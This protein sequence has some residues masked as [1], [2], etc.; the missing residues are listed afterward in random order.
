MVKRVNRF[1]VSARR[2]STYVRNA[3]NSDSKSEHWPSVAVGQQWEV[4]SP[5]KVNDVLWLLTWSFPDD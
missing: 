2:Q 4:T 3:L 1:R 5:T